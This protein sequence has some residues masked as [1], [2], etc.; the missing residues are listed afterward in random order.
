MLMKRQ[1]APAAKP[2]AQR[3][4]YKGRGSRYDSGA[5]RQQFS[6]GRNNS[7]QQKGE[8]GRAMGGSTG[9]TVTP[10]NMTH[11]MG[12]ADKYKNTPHRA[13]IDGGRSSTKPIN[14][15]THVQGMDS[16]NARK[17]RDYDKSVGSTL[18]KIRDASA[19]ANAEGPQTGG[20]RHVG[21]NSAGDTM[22]ADGKVAWT[23][24]S[25]KRR[26]MAQMTPGKM[27]RKKGQSRL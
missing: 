21:T 11:N 13:T 2:V 6:Q 24:D 5:E 18:N 4:V 20:G 16:R 22:R 8:I 12:M 14:S 15:A 10:V 9:Q 17:Y 1:G 27:G 3:G 23:P 25:A 7:S 19:R 26:S